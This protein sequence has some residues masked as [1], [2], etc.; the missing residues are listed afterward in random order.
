MPSTDFGKDGLAMSP[1]TLAINLR[2]GNLNVD[3]SGNEPVLSDA[4]EPGSFGLRN[5]R[6]LPLGRPR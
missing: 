1:E 3:R 2:V 6:N 4:P 5:C